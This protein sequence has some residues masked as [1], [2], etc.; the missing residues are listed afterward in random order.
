[1][2]IGLIARADQTGLGIQSKEFFDHIPCKA[3]VIDSSALMPELALL[4]PNLDLYP[5]QQAFRL[6]RGSGAVGG[7]PKAVVDEFLKDIGVL[8]AIETPY[9]YNIF[10]ECKDRG[11]KTVLQPNYEFLDYPSRLPPPDLFA[12]PSMWNYE[13]I[14]GPKMFLPVPVNA[15]KFK[16][17]MRARTFVHIG[18]RPFL[19]DRNGTRVFA[20]ALRYVKSNI[21]AEIKGQQS[22][23]VASVNPRVTL[24]MDFTSKENYH[25]NYNGGVMVLPRK[26]GGLSLPMN[27]A[28]ASGMPIITTDISPNNLWLPEEWLVPARKVGTFQIKKP[29]DCYE[30]DLAKLAEKIDQF[31]DENFYHAAVSK[32]IDLKESISWDTLLPLYRRTLEGL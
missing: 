23:T 32:A 6:R 30:A 16:H 21:R 10:Q 13:S 31:C 5:G 2:R 29:V 19:Y 12:A 26:Y 3:L 11:I 14:P 24:A 20:N 27:E 28:L 1:M 25:E 17:S 15:K 8:F 7:I 4:K 9:D 18:G 22:V